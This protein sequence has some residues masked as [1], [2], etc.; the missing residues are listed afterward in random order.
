MPEVLWDGKNV[1]DLIYSGWV[2]LVADPTETDSLW[3][4][5]SRSQHWFSGI[6]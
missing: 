1:G 3:T 2:D 6:R 5:T 4:S